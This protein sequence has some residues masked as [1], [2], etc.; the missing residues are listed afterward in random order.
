MTKSEVKAIADTYGM[1]ILRHPITSEAWAV[2]LEVQEEIPALTE[3]CNSATLP[4]VGTVEYLPGA[5]IYK[6]V[7]PTSWFDLC[8]WT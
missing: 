7:C 2:R 6:L 8:G 4:V 3:I 5:V 1:E